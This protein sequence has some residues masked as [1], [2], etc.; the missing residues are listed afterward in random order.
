MLNKELIS[1]ASYKLIGERKHPNSKINKQH[2][3]HFTKEETN[4]P[5]DIRKR[6]SGSKKY[7]Q[8]NVI[9]LPLLEWQS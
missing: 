3:Q 4:W 6:H 7:K 9:S 2:K 1:P 5:L 8:D